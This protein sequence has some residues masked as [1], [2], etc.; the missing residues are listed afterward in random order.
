MRK[1]QSEKP[2]RIPESTIIKQWKNRGRS[3][4]RLLLSGCDRI[5]GHV[6]Q[7]DLCEN[8]HDSFFQAVPPQL[9]V[10]DWSSSH[11]TSDPCADSPST[12]RGVSD[13]TLLSRT[14]DASHAYR[15]N[16]RRDSR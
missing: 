11:R 6:I 2:S 7:Q 14:R 3:S 5:G 1:R 16:R 4:F 9:D 13:V 8:C 10:F 12:S 15:K